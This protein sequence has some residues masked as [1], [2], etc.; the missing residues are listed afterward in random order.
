MHTPTN[1]RRPPFLAWP[2]LLGLCIFAYA[3]L[4]KWMK[5]PAGSM[6]LVIAGTI[7]LSASFVRAGR[8]P[9]R[10]LLITLRLAIA[11]MVAYAV[12]RLLY[13]PQPWVLAAGAIALTAWGIV[14]WLAD[15]RARTSAL[16]ILLAMLGGT[17][18]L[19]AT[20]VHA[21]YG[22]M[23][24]QTPGAK[25]FLHSGCGH[26]YRYSWLLYQDE[27]YMKSVAMIDSAIA[28]S[29]DYEAATQADGEWLRVKLRE[30]RTR[31]EA[32]T[33]DRFKELD[34]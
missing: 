32:H 23:N 20:P 1:L 29:N 30:T 13:W 19:M 33:W 11:L 14:R 26:W 28:V 18:T 25:P 22:Y 8:G 3:L 34:Q 4:S 16:I 6:L 7:L 24:F 17:V 9:D 21:L 27:Q 12:F 2:F 5:W 31:I 10:G 15:E